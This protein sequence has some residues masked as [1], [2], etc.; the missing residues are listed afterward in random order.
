MNNSGQRTLPNPPVTHFSQSENEKLGLPGKV[1]HLNQ[2]LGHD[3]FFPINSAAMLPNLLIA[4]VDTH[5]LILLRQFIRMN[6]TAV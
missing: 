2:T 3:G 6:L 1:H 4:I 5:S